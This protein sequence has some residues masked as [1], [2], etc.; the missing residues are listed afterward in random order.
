MEVFLEVTVQHKKYYA[1]FM[2]K[3]RQQPE[4]RSCYHVSGEYDFLV[5]ADVS[6]EKNLERLERSVRK[7]TGVYGVQCVYALQEII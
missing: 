1:G 7:I 2:E 6:S 4:V 5:K 3:I